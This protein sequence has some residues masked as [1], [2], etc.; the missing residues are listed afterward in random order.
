[1]AKLNVKLWGKS[2]NSAKWLPDRAAISI[3]PEENQGNIY[4]RTHEWQTVS[5]NLK[6]KKI[7]ECIIEINNHSE[8]FKWKGTFNE[9]ID[10][11]K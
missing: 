11:L 1:M 2:A 4:V 9:L 8:S 10:K 5:G 7:P 6:A 3:F